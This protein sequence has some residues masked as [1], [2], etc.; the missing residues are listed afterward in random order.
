MRLASRFLER[1]LQSAAGTKLRLALPASMAPLEQ[2]MMD[3]RD[4]ACDIDEAAL[5]VSLS[6]PMH[7]SRRA[8]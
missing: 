5:H 1:R 8:P 3:A 6:L 7:F 2:F 4:F